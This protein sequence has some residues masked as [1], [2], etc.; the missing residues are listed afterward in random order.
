[1]KKWLVFACQPHVYSSDVCID[2]ATGEW[3]LS[4]YDIECIA[5]GAGI[6]GCGGGGNP[7]I[8]KLA[9]LEQIRSGKKMRVISAERYSPVLN[10][11]L[12]YTLHDINKK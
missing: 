5:I 7:Y 1:M 8:V 10:H 3:I 9:A 6:L 12:S 11:N 4:E 2:E